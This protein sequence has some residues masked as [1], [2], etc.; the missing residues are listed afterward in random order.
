MDET[1]TWTRTS[2]R[3]RAH[4]RA[5]V[6]TLSHAHT[7]YF[8]YKI[9]FVSSI[10]IALT[11][12]PRE[13][14]EKYQ[15]ASHVFDVRYKI[16]DD[17][18]MKLKTNGRVHIIDK[19]GNGIKGKAVLLAIM[20]PIP[21]TTHSTWQWGWTVNIELPKASK[22]TIANYYATKFPSYA[23]S[24]D[25]EV[26]EIMNPTHELCIRSRVHQRICRDVWTHL[27]YRDHEGAWYPY[28][29][30]GCC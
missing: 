3:T 21:E 22:D 6:D 5:H 29:T 30:R 9:E 28:E 20:K 27:Y 4:T 13:L 23:K 2:A 26:L 15:K 1:H 25:A 8:L 18:S 24:A 11:M 17:M 14:I 10:D 19:V 7:L 12:T 16:G